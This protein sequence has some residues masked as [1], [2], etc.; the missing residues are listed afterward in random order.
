VVAR[1]SL[2]WVVNYDSTMPAKPKNPSTPPFMTRFP[3]RPALSLLRREGT[4]PTSGGTAGGLRASDDN[5]EAYRILRQYE[6]SLAERERTLGEMETRLADRTR[7]LDEMEALLRA[8]E[9]LLAATRF[10]DSTNA[11]ALSPR[12]AA[13]LTELKAEVERQEKSLRE[14]QH[15]LR[16]REKFIEESETRL[17][18]KVQEQQ[19]KETEL[20]Q[21]EE[22]LSSRSEGSA[23]A[24]LPF[25]EFRE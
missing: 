20:E 21:R 6:Q 5:V 16:E 13:A 15:A 14:S 8:R 4:A 11:N 1:D 23:P 3:T 2:A 25:D 24:P 19:E 12:E 10:R 22:D 18:A 7:D 9:A 17:F